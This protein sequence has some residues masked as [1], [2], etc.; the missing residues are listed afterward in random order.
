M[1]YNVSS[2]LL[3]VFKELLFDFLQSR[4]AFKIELVLFL[5]LTHFI[6]IVAFKLL[7]VV[8]VFF[9]G[10]GESSDL[11]LKS[12]LL[13]GVHFKYKAF[14][15]KSHLYNTAIIFYSLIK[16]LGHSWSKYFSI[17]GKITE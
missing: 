2:E 5:V 4:L 1:S 11:N 9:E 14:N 13:R 10:S 6:E 17:G 15:S 16:L 8:F 3:V 7:L 12:F